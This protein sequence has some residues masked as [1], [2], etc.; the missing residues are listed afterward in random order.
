[1]S[2]PIYNFSEETVYADNPPKQTDIPTVTSFDTQRKNDNVENRNA[3]HDKSF[4]SQ[5]FS[6]DQYGIIAE[7]LNMKG[8]IGT[9]EEDV[10]E[11]PLKQTERPMVT[12][13]PTSRKN[14]TVKMNDFFKHQFPSSITSP[15]NDMSGNMNE[16][17]KKL[18]TMMYKGENK[19]RRSNK[20]L[21][22]YVCKVC[23][24]EEKK[25]HLKSHIES[26]HLEGMSFQCKRCGK[27]SKTRN[28]LKI[29]NSH[30]HTN[31]II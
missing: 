5:S 19:I 13:I 14:D 1:M 18:E 30:F 29:H 31:I 4:I 28:A 23:G 25:S 8:L 27:T 22:A 24:K 2:S 17:D 20:M 6:E 16:L 7:K 9:E 15:I 26:N 12:I 10:E 11:Y 21:P 3:S